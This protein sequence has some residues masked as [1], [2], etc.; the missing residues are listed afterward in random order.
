MSLSSG[1]LPLS[2]CACEEFCVVLQHHSGR[3][4]WKLRTRTSIFSG[5]IT[6]K[7][8]CFDPDNS[9]HPDLYPRS[10]FG[11][12]LLKNYFKKKVHFLELKF[13]WG[14][15]PEDLWGQRIDHFSLILWK[16]S[17]DLCWLPVVPC[18]RAVTGIRFLHCLFTTD[19]IL[20]WGNDHDINSLLMNT[21]R[22]E[23][24]SSGMV[25]EGK[26]KKNNLLTRFYG[27]KSLMGMVFLGSNEQ[28]AQQQVS[29][30]VHGQ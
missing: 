29:F 11:S 30:E 22:E 20:P 3:Y 18:D 6:Q 17:G 1:K 15:F 12:L 5:K 19:L 25:E 9:N 24:R 16:N 2:H 26:K 4:S 7:Y 23:K 14:G 8:R 10:C 28:A 21:R 27:E 13:S